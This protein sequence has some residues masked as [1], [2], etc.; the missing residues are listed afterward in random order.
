MTCSRKAF[1]KLHSWVV[2]FEIREFKVVELIDILVPS[3]I[4]RFM[5]PTWGPSGADSTQV[6]PMLAPWTLLSGIYFVLIKG[7]RANINIER[8]TCEAKLCMRW[9]KSRL[10]MAWC[11][12]ALDHLQ[13]QCRDIYRHDTGVLDFEC[14]DSIINFYHALTVSVPLLRTCNIIYVIILCLHCHLRRKESVVILCSM[15][16][17]HEKETLSTSLDIWAGNPPVTGGFPSQKPS[18]EDPWCFFWY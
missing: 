11:H 13:T 17:C 10:S 4:A 3:L 15:W 16:F 14:I 1:N 18:N 7:N 9:S 8:H 12:S 6:G 5:A 2:P